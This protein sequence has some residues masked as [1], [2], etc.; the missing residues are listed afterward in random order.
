MW[1]S[2]VHR[3]NTFLAQGRLHWPFPR[4]CLKGW[5]EVSSCPDIP[6]N[7]AEVN[8]MRRGG[9]LWANLTINYVSAEE[10]S[11]KATAAAPQRL[12]DSNLGSSGN[13]L[14]NIQIKAAQL[15]RL[16]S[17]F[18]F[19]PFPSRAPCSHIQGWKQD[20]LEAV[21]PCADSK[22]VDSV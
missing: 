5:P 4:W 15:N 8:A 6:W 16:K 14:I 17:M 11:I 9:D 13:T 1:E 18:P 3:E 22:N 12:P 10:L 21:Q 7:T 19:F 20:Q 2:H